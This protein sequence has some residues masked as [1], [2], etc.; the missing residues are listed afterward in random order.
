MVGVWWGVVGVWWGC[1]GV[2]WECGG[3]V[4]WLW[5]VCGGGVVGCGGCVVRNLCGDFD[6]R[7]VGVCGVCS[8]LHIPMYTE[9]IR[10]FVCRH[11]CVCSSRSQCVF[12]IYM[13]FWK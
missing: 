10:G 3:G 13:G 12:L 1:G 6:S 11:I 5:W 9:Y 2:W 4:V 8:I 7:Q